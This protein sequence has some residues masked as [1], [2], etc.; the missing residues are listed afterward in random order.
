MNER[1]GIKPKVRCKRC[2]KFYIRHSRYC[3][4]CDKCWKEANK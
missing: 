4:L 2:N 3:K 1:K